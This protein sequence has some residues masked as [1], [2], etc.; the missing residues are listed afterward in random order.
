MLITLKYFR[1]II[2]SRKLALPLCCI[3]HMLSSCSVMPSYSMENIDIS[4]NASSPYI[5]GET[6]NIMILAE[7]EQDIETKNNYYIYAI[8]SLMSKKQ[9]LKVSALWTQLENTSLTTHQAITAQI[10]KAKYLLLQ[11]K[12]SQALKKLR[13]LANNNGL[14]IKEANTVFAILSITYK[15]SNDLANFITYYIKANGSDD[16]NSNRLLL[17]TLSE[18]NP[19]TL[20]TNIT[21]TDNKD[22]KGWLELAILA[23]TNL[24]KADIADWQQAY[25][26]HSG[27]TLITANNNYNV[28][29]IAIMLPLQGDIAKTSNSI[30]QGFFA[31]YY[32]NKAQNIGPNITVIDTSDSSF[33]TELKKLIKTNTPDIIIGP[34]TKEEIDS[35]D[36]SISPESL[37]IALNNGGT[38]S[39]NN[40]IHFSLSPKDETN[41]V[42]L[43]VFNKGLNHALV[44]TSEEPWQNKISEQFAQTWKNLAGKVTVQY[45]NNITPLSAQLK[46]SLN[47]DKSE[48]RAKNLEQIIAAK[49]KF[50]PSR[51]T[52]IDMIFLA[53][54]PRQ[55]RQIKPLLKYYFAGDIPVYS[56]STIFNTASNSYKD[57]DLNDIRFCD[58]DWIV[59][60]SPQDQVQKELKKLW[61]KDFNTHKRLFAMGGDTAKIVMNINTLNA[62]DGSIIKGYTGQLSLEG[63]NILRK[64]QWFKFYDGT[65]KLTANY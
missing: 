4:Q 21:N 36:P 13:S 58:S 49:L 38:V 28:D 43:D 17:T 16:Y 37:I 63:H 64:L 32:Q 60:N 47:I 34:I 7:Q 19:K 42:A 30:L 33:N 10:L 25:N 46:S 48:N 20:Q 29:N 1:N 18:Y 45:V 40:L 3:L 31:E 62:I 53:T 8:N 57:V 44:F 14:T 41:K 15:N 35:I 6:K 23:Q 55:A 54:S 50:T 56:T 27:N 26:S 22:I 59:T 12:N 24:G 65:P 11:H 52:D 9:L 51:R 2:L 39:A 61:P 5:P